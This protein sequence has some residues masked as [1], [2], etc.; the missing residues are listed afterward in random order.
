MPSHIDLEPMVFNPK[1]A[2][3]ELWTMYHAYR[4][5]RH[6]E[7]RPDD[8]YWPD[9]L[10]EEGLKRDDP[11]NDHH[12]YLLVRDGRIISSFYAGRVKPGTP[13]WDTNRHFLY[14]DA[15]VLAGERRHGIGTMWAKL[16]LGIMQDWDSRVLTLDTEEDD[17]HEFLRWLGA[18]QKS[19]G[20]ENRLDL[21]EV[22]WDMVQRWV[23]EGGAKSPDTRLV[24]HENRVPEEIWA[25]YCPAMSAMLN[26][27]PFDDLDHGDIVFTPEMQ[28]ERYDFMDKTGGAHHT[29]LTREPDGSISSV[30]DIGYQPAQADRVFQYFTGVRPDCR[31]RGLG[32]LIKATM[33]QYIRQAYP[34]AHWVITGNANSNDPML[35]INRRL[36]FKTYRTGISYQ[37]NRDALAARLAGL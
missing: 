21:T 14:A 27:M 28:R 4:H 18:E 31:G 12:R 6:D 29:V 2:S 7:V 19:I 5:T 20:A 9:H 34:E 15:G 8:P 22:D 1:E 35:A 17:G 33:L 3:P 24:F 23:T 36:G 25:E 16:V 37:I 32:K 11:F 13:E 30:T 26:T 10:T